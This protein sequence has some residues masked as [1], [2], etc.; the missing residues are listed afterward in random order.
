MPSQQLLVSINDGDAAVMHHSTHQVAN[1]TSMTAR[2]RS[3]WQTLLRPNYQQAPTLP[4]G[5]P[6]ERLSHHQ[7]SPSP[8]GTSFAS[9]PAPRWTLAAAT[10]SMPPNLRNREPREPLPSSPSQ[11]PS[12]LLTSGK[13][14]MWQQPARCRQPGAPAFLTTT[15]LSDGPLP[16]RAGWFP[17]NTPTLDLGRQS[18]SC[19]P[20]HLSTSDRGYAVLIEPTLSMASD[21]P[22]KSPSRQ[23]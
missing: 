3:P 17:T 2:S 12:Q 7:T 15:L 19:C 9:P 6:S 21:L 8:S 23:H 14:L 4:C 10:S 22:A 1:T 11:L 13:S 18:F 20:P 5:P 16:P